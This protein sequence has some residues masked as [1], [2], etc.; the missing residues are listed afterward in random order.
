MFEALYIPN[1]ENPLLFLADSGDYN[2][3]KMIIEN[4][5]SGEKLIF[6]VSCQFWESFVQQ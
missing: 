4:S 3:L 2:G 1:I 5:V 6:L